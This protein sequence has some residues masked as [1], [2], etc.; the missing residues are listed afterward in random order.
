[1]LS[2]I[3]GKHCI[4][5]HFSWGS[6]NNSDCE[7]LINEKGIQFLPESLKK[8]RTNARVLSKPLTKW[9][10]CSILGWGFCRRCASA[11]DRYSAPRRRTG[12]SYLPRREKRKTS[13]PEWIL[14]E[15]RYVDTVD[16]QLLLAW[17][18]E[19]IENRKQ[20]QQLSRLLWREIV[21]S[22]LSFYHITAPVP[23]AYHSGA[24]TVYIIE[25]HMEQLRKHAQLADISSRT[26][27]PWAVTRGGGG[28]GGLWRPE[29]PSGGEG[30]GGPWAGPWLVIPSE[31]W[32][33]AATMRCKG[34]RKSIM[35]IKCPPHHFWLYWQQ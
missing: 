33:T 12:H 30:G 18:F 11:A 17:G 25:H 9:R 4:L 8:R 20:F 7:Y 24:N 16:T 26:T 27:M 15:M 5:K 23:W 3:R 32:D 28:G 19:E 35:R 13:V 31:R 6:W 34:M 10:P 21:W 29:K 22:I 2:W 1:M 14:C